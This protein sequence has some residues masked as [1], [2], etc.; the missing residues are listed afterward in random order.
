LAHRGYIRHVAAAG[1]KRVNREFWRDEFQTTIDAY[2]AGDLAAGLTACE[3]LLSLAELPPDIDLQTRRNLVYYT[4][5]LTTIVPATRTLPIDFAVPD[6]WS[7]F[8]PSV[9]FG[10]DGLRMIVRSSN[11][12]M[13]R[14]LRYTI[15]D[16][17]GVIRTT[18]YLVDLSPE[19]DIERV[20]PIADAALRPDPPPFP[21]SGFEDCRLF[22]SSD[23]W[24]VSATVRDQNQEGICQIAMFRL[25]G[26][27]AVDLQFLS[28]AS[29][30]R[31]EKNWMPVSPHGDDTLRFIYST[32]PVVVLRYDDAAETVSPE[33]IH[34]GPNIARNFSG[35]TQAIAV[36]GGRLV[37]VHEAVNFNDGGRV[38]THRWAWFDAGWN[39]AKVSPPFRFEETGVEFAAGLARSG[40]DLVISYGV[41]DREARLASLPLAEVLPLLAPPL[42]GEETARQMRDAAPIQFPMT[43]RPL[44]V[45]VSTIAQE[46]TPFRPSS[47]TIV[48]MTMTGNSRDIIGDA[49]RG[50]VDWVDWC[51]VVDTGISDDTLEIARDIAGDK[52]IVREFPWRDDF[53][54][55][56]NFALAAAAE[57]GADW[58]MVLDSDERIMP[59]GHDVRA[60]LAATEFD[61]LHVNHVGG[62]YGKE[63]FFRL[64]ARGH[65]V[66]PTHEAFI[67]SG[68]R[69]GTL[70]GIEFDELG[71]SA[72]DYRRKAERDVAILTRHTAEHPGDP[73]WFYYLG[74]SLSGLGRLDEAIAAFRA[75]ASLNGWDEEGAWAM[76]R[77]AD[78]YLKL[79]RPTDAIETLALG[80]SKHA[81]L[82]ELPWLAAY[83]SWQAD[84]PAQA[85]YWARLALSMGHFSGAG[86]TVPRV[87]F[88]HPPALWEGPYDVLR[89]ALRR[90]GDDAGA[91]EAERMFEEAKAAREQGKAPGA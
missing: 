39:L 24:R 72:E 33:I 29:N 57:T 44:P 87:G 90:L 14:Q 12:T 26:A 43:E 82:A 5:A 47:P 91:D 55:A 37:L 28:E 10:P 18:N 2:Y 8:N 40:E 79:D 61:A 46:I 45:S 4:P 1:G 81:G 63:R 35:G 71:K 19:L 22:F 23:A 60:R 68:A 7:R 49:L 66:G 32:S 69:V 21:V 42:D 27:T 83:A 56:R 41:W 50:V 80:M 3:N 30:R 85:V 59:D 65:Y 62:V 13:T 36:D 89:F 58:A 48:S 51:L 84:R 73:R 54:A 78:C 11:Y 86:K 88:R 34:P 9:A 76:Y 75:C 77:A 17:G 74:D 70:G 31:H 67:A 25:D 64:P 6:G 16:V 20:V 38:Y 15:N 53:A 52:L